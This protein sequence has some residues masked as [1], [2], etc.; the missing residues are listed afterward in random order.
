[1][2]D[3]MLPDRVGQ[4]RSRYRRLS[5]KE[6]IPLVERK[7]RALDCQQNGSALNRSARA[8]QCASTARAGFMPADRRIPRPTA[9]AASASRAEGGEYHCV[10]SDANIVREAFSTSVEL[11]RASPSQR[12][13]GSKTSR[14]RVDAVVSNTLRR[15]EPHL[16][17]RRPALIP[18]GRRCRAGCRQCGDTRCFFDLFRGWAA[19]WP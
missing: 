8:G 9:G 14:T 4:G 16:H 10:Y 5:Q 1:M 11:R 19:Q 12:R 7:S 17:P 15:L 3:Q 18:G 6:S 2:I 13:A